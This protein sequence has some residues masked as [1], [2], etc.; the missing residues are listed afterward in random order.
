[1]TNFVL[2]LALLVGAIGLVC[3]VDPAQA[4]RR[5]T[6]CDW[7]GGDFADP[8]TSIFRRGGCHGGGGGHRRLARPV[9]QP[10]EPPK[11]LD[12]FEV[13]RSITAPTHVS[14]LA[15]GSSVLKSSAEPLRTVWTAAGGYG[16]SLLAVTTR[17]RSRNPSVNFASPRQGSWMARCG[18]PRAMGLKRLCSIT[19]SATSSRLEIL[20]TSPGRTSG[21]GGCMPTAKAVI[22]S[23]RMS[24]HFKR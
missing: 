2:R 21:C 3:L 4:F 9:Q 6:G 17:R 14:R 22:W 19:R 18:G 12:R 1:M 8:A 7:I 15:R 13:R 10:D 20:S 5:P 24:L 23:M 16:A 11:L